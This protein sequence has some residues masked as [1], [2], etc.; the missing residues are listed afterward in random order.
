[1]YA[2]LI[3]ALSC[4]TP[5]LSSHIISYKGKLFPGHGKQVVELG[6]V[7]FWVHSFIPFGARNIF[8][9]FSTLCVQNVNNTGTKYVRI[10][11]QTSF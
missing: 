6:V 2:A 1:M 11:K 3:T 8:L 4:K 10:M 7:K 9:N 5:E